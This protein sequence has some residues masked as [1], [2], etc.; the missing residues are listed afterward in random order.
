MTEN[1]HTADAEDADHEGD[2]DSYGGIDGN[3]HSGDDTDGDSDGDS[4]GGPDDD[5]DYVDN[6]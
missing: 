5:D 3:D 2:R 6:D 1:D 4:D